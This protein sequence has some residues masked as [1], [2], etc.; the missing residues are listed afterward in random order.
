[1]AYC[2]VCG[3]E[4]A[5]FYPA[6]RNWLCQSCRQD[7]PSKIDRTSFN[8]KYWGKE[9]S[10]VPESIRREFYEDYLASTCTF[11]QYVKDTTTLI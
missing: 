5:V 11:A 2:H 8:R 4:E 3:A 1:M 9:I 7:T 6:C 10:E